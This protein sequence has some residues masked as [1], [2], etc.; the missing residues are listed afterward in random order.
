MHRIALFALLCTQLC[1]CGGQESGAPHYLRRQIDSLKAQ[2]AP[3]TRTVL[4]H[5][6]LKKD[7]KGPYIKGETD[8]I[9]AFN[10]LRALNVRD[11]V[12][13]WP[14]TVA[15]GNKR[16]GVVH[17]SVGNVR[18]K[19]AHHRELVTQALL[20]TPLRLLGRKEDWFLVQ[21]PDLY[22]GWIESQ[23]FTA[24]SSENFAIW[25]GAPKFFYKN[26]AGYVYET[27]KEARTVADIVAGAIISRKN[28][29]KHL[30]THENVV[31]PDGREGWV[32]KREGEYL[33][34]LNTFEDHYDTAAMR[35]FL[36]KIIGAP[37]LWGGTSTKGMD[38]S[39]FTKTIFFVGGWIIPRDASQQAQEGVTVERTALRP[40]DLLFFGTKGQKSRITHV[41]LWL[42]EGQF[43]HSLGRVRIN[44][45]D[46]SDE[47]YAPDLLKKWLF[48]KRYKTP[49][50]HLVPYIKE[51][52]YYA[53]S[54]K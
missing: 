16:W 14:D 40:F 38:C 32:R 53:P 7:E 27:P 39:G 20:G 33:E 18:S 44:S 10:A 1:G 42:G 5:I 50:K 36:P 48:S 49:S 21:L 12:A 26:L 45:T 29:T 47:A 9:V 43:I 52:H 11:S 46:P 22:L 51:G 2:Y 23:A 19:P 8:Q 15:L 34:A 6:A 13:L 25:R 37:Y 35:H 41:A 31:Y 28:P 30:K 3:D 17:N 24:M 54:S 4:W